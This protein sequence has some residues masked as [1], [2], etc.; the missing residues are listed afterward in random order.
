MDNCVLNPDKTTVPGFVA[1]CGLA[2]GTSPPALAICQNA[3]HNAGG[4]WNYSTQAPAGRH[5]ACQELTATQCNSLHGDLAICTVPTECQEGNICDQGFKIPCP[6][7]NS[8][9]A[10]VATLCPANKYQDTAG[11]ASC[12]PMKMCNP[13]QFAS[14]QG[15]TIADRACASCP[16]GTS[17]KEP[18]ISAT[19]APC[20]QPQYQTQTGQPTC[21]N[22]TPCPSATPHLSYT[23]TTTKPTCFAGIDGCSVLDTATQK[24]TTCFSAYKLLAGKCSKRPVVTSLT[25]I[26]SKDSTYPSGTQTSTVVTTGATVDGTV[27]C[28][29]PNGTPAAGAACPAGS[30]M[31]TA[32]NA[33]FTLDATTKTCVANTCTCSNGTAVTGAACTTNDTNLCAS[34]GSD[35]MLDANHTCVA[36]T[37]SIATCGPT[38]KATFRTAA[39]GS[40]NPTCSPTVPCPAGPGGRYCMKCAGIGTTCW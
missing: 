31:C 28:T 27:A 38:N 9:T 2:L 33:G 6:K 5:N 37:G 13:G 19:C 1:A 29:C 32:C 12:K 20:I 3:F 23:D 30:V 25:L 8:C 24:C 14:N 18:G 16:A 7:G 17:Q 26:S 4:D 11:S 39:P 34:C 21:I 15:S 22:P 40:P 35:F 10:G 36:S